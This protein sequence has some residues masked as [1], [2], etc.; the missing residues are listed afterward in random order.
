[1]RERPKNRGQKNRTRKKTNSWERRFPGIFRTYVPLILPIF[2]VFS[3]FRWFFSFRKT[4]HLLNKYLS[5]TECRFQP[6]NISRER[7]ISPKLFRPK[8]FR[9][10]PRS[11]SVPTCMFFHDLEGLTEAFGGMS[12]RTFAPKT[13]S[14]QIF[15][16]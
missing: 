5:L 6:D 10:R 12:T 15:R 9:G 14:F 1:M 4:L 13:S 7:K 8:F 2:S 16:S 11:M 3:Y